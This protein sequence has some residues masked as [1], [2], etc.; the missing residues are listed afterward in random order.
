M[1]GRCCTYTSF[2]ATIARYRNSL[3]LLRDSS[4]VGSFVVYL[5]YGG[6]TENFRYAS[7]NFGGRERETLLLFDTTGVYARKWGTLFK[8]KVLI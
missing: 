1:R 6:E 2:T 5:C 4:L 8:K 3:R 7:Y